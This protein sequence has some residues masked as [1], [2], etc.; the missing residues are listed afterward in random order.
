MKNQQLLRIWGSK[1]L[2]IPFLALL[3]AVAGWGSSVFGQASTEEASSTTLQAVITTDKPDYSPGETVEI[4]G[5]LFQPFETVTLSIIHIEPG[6][7]DPYHTHD[8]WTVNA[9]KYGEFISSWYVNDV[10]LNTT[11]FLTA[12][13][14]MN[15]YAETT[16]TDSPK[17]G[18]VSLGSQTP[19]HI[20]P[21]ESAT[22]AFEIIRDNA[23]AAF[24]ADLSF[25]G[26]PVGATFS[27]SSVNV[28]NGS[29]Y[30]GSVIITVPSTTPN[31][32]YPIVL[33][34]ETDKNPG[35]ANR[36]YA[37][38]T[39][40]L[41]VGHGFG[42][43]PPVIDPQ[44]E[45]MTVEC[46]G[47]GNSDALN[48]WLADNGG[49]SATASGDCGEIAW[50][51][52]FSTLSDECG[53]TGSATVT[54]IVTDECG[55]TS[56]TLATFTIQ[57]ATPPVITTAASD[58]TVECD[59]SG[60][61]IELT[62]WLNSNGG[63]EASDICGGANWSNDFAAL[64]DECGA[65]GSATVTF[66]VTDECGNT[67]TTLATFII[68]DTTPPEIT[69]AASD[70]TVECDGSGN[71]GDLKGWLTNI[72][73]AIASDDCSG[74]TWSNDFNALSDD[75]G[76]TGSAT[77][78]F[79]ATDDCDNSTTTSATFT[80]VDTQ[81]PIINSSVPCGG[82]TTVET[83]PGKCT[84]IAGVNLNAS[85]EDNCSGVFDASWE[86]VNPKGAVTT[87]VGSLEGV[88][89]LPGK[90]TITW[91]A[92]DDC[93]NKATACSYDVKVNIATTTIV[94]VSG[95]HARY[96][97]K[98][99]FYANVVTNC[100][101][102]PLRGTVEFFLDG[103]PLSPPG[104]TPVYDIHFDEDGYPTTV[105]ATLIH[106]L[107]E[108]PKLAN[109]DDPNSAQP[110]IVTAVFTPDP[111][112]SPYYSGSEDEVG[113]PLT[114]NPRKASPFGADGFYTGDELAWT[115]GPSSSTATLT[116]TALIKDNE[117]PGGDVRGARVT[118]Y[119]VSGSTRTPIPSAQR[120]PV[121]LIDMT[122]GSV[123]TASA[124][125]Q[126]NIGNATSETY[127]IAV[128]ISRAYFN[129]VF[130]AEAVSFVTVSKPMAGGRIFGD[131]KLCN[132]S[133]SAG[134]VRG[135]DGGKTRFYFDV[136]Y[137]KKQTN[138]Q[139]KVTIFIKSWYN[140]SGLLD[141]N[142]GD[143][144][145]LYI[146]TS[147]AISL[148]AI[149]APTDAQ[150]SSKAN[151]VEVLGDGSTQSVDAGATL[152]LNMKDGK[153]DLLGITYYRRSGGVWYSNNWDITGKTIPS[154]LCCGEL[155]VSNKS[156]L[157]DDSVI[158]PNAPFNGQ[159]ALLVYP[160]PTFG[161]VTFK[162]IVAESAMT[163]IDIYSSTGQ[164]VRRAW[165]GYTK[166]GEYKTVELESKL[167]KGLYFIQMRTGSEIKT[168]RLVV[169]NTY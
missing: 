120:L 8:N 156:G 75:C 163:T 40:S 136:N 157:D 94:G 78:I 152:Q 102:Y 77:V 41:V 19:G 137:N 101:G 144:P 142:I 99:T 161:P 118:F 25:T 130:D 68:E 73:G 58:L 88:E 57:D 37:T 104:I 109:E 169:S 13:G 46:D 140:S 28:I 24:T 145:H 117:V 43:T 5:S 82:S 32:V 18:S 167:A 86:I 52:D 11:L 111:I 51:N 45:N 59:G 27:P 71:L 47:S 26:L 23:V 76:A 61:E 126:L 168:A 29:N 16:F 63:A 65:T 33:L 55:N 91:T 69:T 96:M 49:A 81:A 31:G 35:S 160:N 2:L 113:K 108:F 30:Y 123:G 67:S 124:I 135:I 56:T 14:D 100:D 20:H 131:G 62:N 164:I 89:F 48:A 72:G 147:N 85:A 129:D 127:Q 132:N 70:L 116:M 162:F 79:T 1:L 84:Y 158:L 125:V 149:P 134:L 50:S 97:D 105:R 151:M 154:A 15:S 148:L 39:G 133:S 138:P 121:N 150:F 36:D 17:I 64:S 7:P 21:G 153:P 165:E 112:E 74:V 80:I 106:Q 54:F 4:T 114:I 110:Y 155:I 115:T 60:N 6:M 22:Y 103:E 83:T 95:P 166:G 38:T 98:V 34:V 10:E 66:T 141:R 42:A 93:G 143:D 87:G 3:L 128:G 107:V 159:S 139:G 90:S 44:A 119:L 53:A 92:E 12:N 122:D 9:D 146:I